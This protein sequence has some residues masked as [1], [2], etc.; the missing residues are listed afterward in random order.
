MSVTLGTCDNPSIPNNVKHN[1]M[2]DD[3]LFEFGAILSF[4]CHSNFSL[5]G[6]SSIQCIL[7]RYPNETVWNSA[8]PICKGGYCK[9]KKKKKKEKKV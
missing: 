6:P 5:V 1:L 3:Q 7:G 9:K 4:E 8:A 2:Y